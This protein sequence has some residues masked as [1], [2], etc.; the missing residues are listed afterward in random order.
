[1]AS[2]GFDLIT[3]GRSSIDLYSND[4]GAPFEEITTF[5]AYVGGSPTNIAVGAHRLGLQVAL[6]TAIGRD[7][8]GDFVLHFLDAEGVDTSYIPVKEGRRTSAVL[9][10]SK[11]EIVTPG[12]IVS[13]A[14]VC[15][16]TLPSTICELS[17]V[18]SVVM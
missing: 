16:T 9:L 5:A 13:V 1:M 10:G 18:V 11:N 8:V 3:L 14:E 6:L 2:Q 15:T 4:M 17:Q 12:S 7:K